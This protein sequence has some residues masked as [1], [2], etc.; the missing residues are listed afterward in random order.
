MEDPAPATICSF[1]E[2]HLT[3]EEATRLRDQ[4][5]RSFCKNR[6]VLWTGL[7]EEVVLA[8]ANKHEFQTLRM[9]MGPLMDKSHPDC[10]RRTA[11][12]KKWAQ[13]IH[14]ASAIFALKICSGD[15]VT[16]L[17]QPPPE[18]FHPSGATS[19]QVLEEP[20]IKGKLGNRSVKQIQIIHPMA[21]KVPIAPY[22]LWPT[23][24]VADWISQHGLGKGKVKWR[25][26]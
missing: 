20:I 23:D 15:V 5:S 13:Y 12:P 2:A 4:F 7:N 10:P 25:E 21:T 17:T 14:G 16:L 18:R 11:S 24:D 3:T 6:Q 9:A 19:Y 26:V 8:W 1:I 22:M